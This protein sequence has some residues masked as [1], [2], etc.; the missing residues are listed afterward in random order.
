MGD[1]SPSRPETAG[2]RHKRLR[3]FIYRALRSTAVAPS[4]ASPHW[5]LRAYYI[6]R[7]S[8]IQAYAVLL[9]MYTAMYGGR[10]LNAAPEPVLPMV[11]AC[12]C[13]PAAA[14]A[15]ECVCA[16]ALLMLSQCECSPAQEVLKLCE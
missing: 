4:A 10:M 13:A 7:I 1:E 9:H 16:P 14:I 6:G 15:T 11:I 8:R 12:V 3:E 2:Y 5:K